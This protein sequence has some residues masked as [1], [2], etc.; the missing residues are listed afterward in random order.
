M[1]LLLLNYP[2]L[3]DQL[4]KEGAEVVSAGV[5]SDCDFVFTNREYTLEMILPRIPFQPDFIL[6]MDSLKRVL[7]SGL[8]DAPCPLGAFCLDST[9]NRFWHKPLAELCDIVLCDQLPEALRLADEGLN[10]HWFPLAADTSIYKPMGMKKSCDLTFIGSRHGAN[11]IK[12]ENILKLLGNRINIRIFDGNPPV[13]AEEASEIYNRSRMVLNENL[14][15]SVNLRMFEAMACETVLLTEDTAPGLSELFT[16]RKHL[17]T[18]NPDDLEEKTE[19]YL[20]HDDECRQIASAGC[21]AVMKNHTLKIRAAKLLKLLAKTTAKR[22]IPGWQKKS[23]MGRAFLG[24]SMKWGERDPSALDHAVRLLGNSVRLEPSAEALFALGRAHYLQENYPGA[25]NRLLLVFHRMARDFRPMLFAGGIL[26]GLG[27]QDLADSY[28]QIAL[29]FAGGNPNDESLIKPGTENFHLFWGRILAQKGDA[30]E[31][32][33][34]KYHLPFPFWSALEHYQRAAEIKPRNW[35]RVGDMLMEYEAPD[36]A[37]A[38][39]KAAEPKISLEKL[40]LAQRKAYLKVEVNRDSSYQKP[41]LTLVMIVKNEAANLGE[42][43]TAVG[44]I[45]DQIVIADTGSDDDTVAVA[46]SFGAE[47]IEIEWMDDFAAARNETLKIAKGRYILYL[48][49]DDRVDPAELRALKRELP[50]DDSHIF[51][52]KLVNEHNGEVCLQKR[53]FPNRK[54][55]RFKGAVH[56]QIFPDEHKFRFI[57]APLTILH[58]GYSDGEMIKAKS[59]R[60]LRIIQRELMINP[61]DYHL[62]YHSAVCLLNLGR[63]LE[64]V[65]QLRMI[66]FNDSVKAEDP[67]IYEHSII[68]LA[69]IFRNMEDMATALKLMQTFLQEL[70]DS[71]MG[72]YYLGMMYFEEQLY[73]E[74]RAEMGSFFRHR[75]KPLGIPLPIEK[76]RGWAHYYLGICLEHQGHFSRAVDEYMEALNR[77]PDSAKLYHDIGRARYKNRDYSG[78]VMYLQ[79][80]LEKHPGD[81]GAR[82]LLKRVQKETEAR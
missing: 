60:N 65:E 56:E 48:D 1:K 8:E 50:L 44:D 71:A 61:G 43:L 59:E 46:K 55:L 18:Y 80:C 12:R 45:P 22:K 28:L 68:M 78:S 62:R 24:Y 21:D 72:H 47:V 9:L 77:L 53:V 29:E 19:Y 51:F 6:F 34:M 37:L 70:P 2:Y 69:R 81:R 41:S 58:T 10:A 7:P 33:L 13:S 30:L 14:F 54:D 27:E 5:E 66:A 67:E 25:M 79:L 49:G 39:Y 15:P 40:R 52:T 64:A 73:S 32:G 76:I 4:R 11:R 16:D 17:L 20:T 26:E 36:Q 57:E 42:L 31:P 82:K 63:Q 38:A 3:V 74:C 75:I 23:A 35:E